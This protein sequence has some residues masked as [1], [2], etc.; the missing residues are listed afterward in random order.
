MPWLPIEY[1]PSGRRANTTYGVDSLGQD[2]QYDGARSEEE[3]LG[4]HSDCVVVRC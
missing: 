4:V 3:E 2:D 1:S